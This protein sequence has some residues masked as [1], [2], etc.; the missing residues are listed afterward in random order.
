MIGLDARFIKKIIIKNRKAYKN[1]ILILTFRDI[2]RSYK[3]LFKGKKCAIKERQ[4]VNIIEVYND[5]EMLE[6]SH[7]E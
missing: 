6:I 7:N 4:K 1:S 5:Y 3:R 2:M